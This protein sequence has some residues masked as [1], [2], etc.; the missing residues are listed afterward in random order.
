MRRSWIVAAGAALVLAAG[1][2]GIASG[3]GASEDVTCQSDGTTLSCPLS[4]PV[5]VTE[6]APGGTVTETATATVTQPAVTETAT[7][8]QTVVSTVTAPP[9]TVTASGTSTPPPTTTAPTTP[10][11]TTPTTT[12]AP[13]TTSAPP[14]TTTTAPAPPA[15]NFPTSATTGVPAGT[16]LRTIKAGDSGTGWRVE[17]GTF[18]VT[19]SGTVIDKFDIP[20]V[21]KIMANDVT[22]KNSRVRAASY[23]TVN[24]SDPPTYYSRLTIVDS[25]IDGLN[26]LSNPGIAV[27]ANAGAT[28]LRVDFHGFGSSGPRLATGTTVQDS[29]IH[30]FVCAPGEHSAGTSANDGGTGIKLLHNNI[31]IS[32]GA[33]GCASAAASIYPDFGSYDGVLIQNN[34]FNGGAYCLYTAQN[35]GKAKN[36]RVEGNTFGRKY[37]PRCGQYGPAAQVASG[38][39]NTFTGNVY[40]D[41]TPVN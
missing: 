4:A 33:N 22:I 3:S 37:Y 20:M 28:Y 14:T 5:T 10:R 25:E 38:N 15:G 16:T 9:V 7:A 26:S 8:T 17:N 40:D 18:Y 36:V 31:D 1:S 41:G 13:T 30:G 35:T 21:A 19:T 12:T 11:T 24:V 39:G 23:Y 29:Y 27:M 2:V 32:T 34:L 6:T